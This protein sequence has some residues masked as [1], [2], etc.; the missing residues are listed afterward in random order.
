MNSEGSFYDEI[1]IKKL[2]NRVEE[3]DNILLS[4]LKAITSVVG[5]ENTE[6]LINDLKGKK[7]G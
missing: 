1:R 3:L 6:K 5:I 7:R 2:E 4:V